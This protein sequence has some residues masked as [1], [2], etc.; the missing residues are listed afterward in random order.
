MT[1]PSRQKYRLCETA[2]QELQFYGTY[3]YGHTG[4]HRRKPARRCV[5][6][7]CLITNRSL[8]GNSGRS[9]LTGPV[10]CLYCADWPRQLLLRLGDGV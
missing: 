2:F 3:S 1:A 4:Q 6:C 5:S 10:W 9:A 7:G 8:G